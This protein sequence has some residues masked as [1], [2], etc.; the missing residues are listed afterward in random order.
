[1]LTQVMRGAWPELSAAL[2]SAGGM[3][4]KP[5]KINDIEHFEKTLSEYDSGPYKVAAFF[6]EI[7]LMNYGGILLHEDYL[8]RA[9]QLCHTH[10]VPAVADEIQ[11][12]IWSPEFFMFREYHLTPDMVSVGKGFPGGEYPASRLLTTAAM[13]NLDQFGAIVTN[14]QEELASIAYL[15]TMAFT[16]ANRVFIKD[17]GDF[18]ES[19]LKVLAQKYPAVI[20]EIA[21]CRHLSAVVFRS[22]EAAA[23]FVRRIKE[24]GIDISAQTYK[25]DSLPAALTKLPLISSQRLIDFVIGV[26]DEVLSDL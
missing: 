17:M 18:Y 1:M 6:H 8:R 4:V 11:S 21:G 12:C 25:A 9:Y 3:V 2:E 16:Q 24:K 15:V 23:T 10:D 26:M 19:E 22:G 13:D 14:G 7:V 20:S 5:V